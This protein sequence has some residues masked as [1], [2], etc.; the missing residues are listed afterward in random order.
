MAHPSPFL[1]DTSAGEHDNRLQH[2]TGTPTASP[3][4]NAKFPNRN[5][6]RLTARRP[7]P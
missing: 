4:P 2:E 6:S 3:H 7:K 1:V 5:G